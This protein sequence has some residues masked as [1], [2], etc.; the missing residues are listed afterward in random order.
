MSDSLSL[1][2][3]QAAAQMIVDEGMDYDQARA[4]AI[5]A[6]TGGE[7]PRQSIPSYVDIEDQVREHLALFHADTHPA[8]LAALRRKALALMDLIADF[9]PYLSGA[10]ANGTATEH[11]E[12]QI[13]TFNDSSKEL[14]IFLLNQGLDPDSGEIAHFRGGSEVEALRI[15]WQGESA[16]IATYPARDLRGAL[17]PD[18]AGRI[19]RYNRQ[20]VRKLLE[21][22]QDDARLNQADV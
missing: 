12:I 14:T 9:D 16:L 13:Q 8:L 6:I 7:L 3:A 19:R 17:K 2:I 11:S 1:E 5:D 22:G 20:G 18:A 4:R 10:V 15:D 21:D